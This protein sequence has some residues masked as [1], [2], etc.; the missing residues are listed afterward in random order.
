MPIKCI[1]FSPKVRINPKRALYCAVSLRSNVYQTHS[2]ARALFMY[3]VSLNMERNIYVHAP[4]I[5]AF[6]A[7]QAGV[8]GAKRYAVRS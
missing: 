5:G 2:Y 7:F 6:S 4:A 1:Y 8:T 3:A